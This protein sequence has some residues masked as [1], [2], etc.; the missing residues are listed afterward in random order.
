VTAVPEVN[1]PPLVSIIIPCFNHGRFLAEAIDS[2]LAQSYSPIEVV[3]VDDGSTD[4][5]ADVAQRYPV[6]LIR[7]PNQGPA[8]AVNAGIRTSHGD[9]VMRLDADDRLAPAYVEKTIKPLL[10]NA[11]VHFVYTP[12]RYFGARTGSYP[13]EKFDADSLA[14]RNYV[15]SS[16]LMRRSSFETVGGYKLDMRG[17]RCEDWDLWLAFAER[18]MRGELVPEPLLEYRQHTVR[19]EV[20]INLR[21]FAGVRREVAM[22]S[23]LGDHHRSAFAAPKLLRRLRL[24]PRRVLR[25]EV[26][27]R[28]AALLLAFHAVLLLRHAMHPHTASTPHRFEPMADHAD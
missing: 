20:T 22:I 27:V 14:E 15:H 28:F 4:Y 18:G 7:Q 9:F 26:S 5:S 23:R 21:S 2:A 19:S 3:V 6:L 13:T 16:A 1:A 10:G 8:A 24:L 17:L 11:S 25:G 12:V